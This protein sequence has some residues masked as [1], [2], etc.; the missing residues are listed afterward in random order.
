MSVYLE[1][2]ARARRG[3]TER[4]ATINKAL[5]TTTTWLKPAERAIRDVRASFLE[6]S[7][8]YLGDA[9]RALDESVQLAKEAGDGSGC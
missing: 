9:F 2:R 7:L 5:S 4:N 1:A 8:Y 3:G 6:A